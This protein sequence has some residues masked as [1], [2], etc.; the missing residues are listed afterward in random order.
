MRECVRERE[1]DTERE[2]Q[3][4][5]DEEWRRCGDIDRLK[6]YN[7]REILLPMQEKKNKKIK[8]LVFHLKSGRPE[9]QWTS[10]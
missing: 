6:V 3:R 1:R 5:R 2:R 7:K 9:I 10:A 4:E 8:D